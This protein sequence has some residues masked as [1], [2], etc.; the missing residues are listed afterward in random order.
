MR[1]IAFVVVLDESIKLEKYALLGFD[2]PEKEG[3]KRIALHKAVEQPTDLLRVP[4]EFPLDCRQ[5]VK[6]LAHRL[7]CFSDGQ[8]RLI[9]VASAIM[10]VA[11][12]Y[13]SDLPLENTAG[14]NMDLLHF[15]TGLAWNIATPPPTH[16]QLHGYSAIY[17]EASVTAPLALSRTA[18]LANGLESRC[19]RRRVRPDLPFNR[20]PN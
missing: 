16:P 8:A 7:Q 2:P 13:S 20:R 19:P 12:V 6:I 10:S 5:D 17:V 14:Y 4:N 9:Q 15:L 18:D 3:A 11:Q 1:R